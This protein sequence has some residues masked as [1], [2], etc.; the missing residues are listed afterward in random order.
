MNPLNYILSNM[1]RTAVVAL[2]AVAA[3]VAWVANLP[4][5][6]FSSED[7][8]DLADLSMQLQSWYNTGQVVNI[9]GHD[10]FAKV[11]EPK[12]ECGCKKG[13]NEALV[14][15]HGFPTSSFD[16]WRALGHLTE[17]CHCMKIVMFDHV[18]YG[19]SAKPK[20]VS[21]SMQS[22]LRELQL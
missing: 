20:H 6:D 14:L 3:I 17:E 15:V 18:G 19:F 2:C 12:T 8:L 10:M 11:V 5:P 16:Y 4:E 9:N 1:S 13:P 7:S 22:A 21:R